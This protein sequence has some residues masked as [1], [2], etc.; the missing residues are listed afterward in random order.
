MQEKNN[1]TVPNV[2]TPQPTVASAVN[3]DLLQIE[4]YLSQHYLFRNNVLSGKYEVAKLTNPQGEKTEETSPFLPLTSERWNTIIWDMQMALPDVKSVAKSAETFVHSDHT[5]TFDPV[6]DYINKLPQ[7]DG[8]DHV[9]QLIGCIPGLNGYQQEWIRTWLRS[10]VAHWMK[11]DSEFGNDVVLLLIGAQGCGKSTFCQRLIPKSLREYYLDHLNLANKFDKEM[12]LARNLLVN[13]DEFD[14]VK[15]SQQAELKHTISKTTVNGRR[16][17]ASVQTDQHRYASFVATTNSRHPLKDPT[18]SRRYLC[19]EIP[20]RQIIDNSQDIDYEQLYAQIYAELKDGKRCYFT[21]EEMILM[22]QAN[23]PYQQNFD[24]TTMVLQCFRKPRKGE[25]VP[26]LQVSDMMMEVYS[27]YPQ[28][29]CSPR[30]N[31][32]LGVALR[33]QGY[34]WKRTKHGAAYYAVIRSG[35]AA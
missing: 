6:A 23:E 30:N 16:I 33:A 12:A 28:L 1:S 11:M 25:A 3:D 8:K 22:Q 20:A 19:V 34:Q 35:Q 32:S 31:V 2:A 26:A 17:Y 13:I 4:E 18:G 29:A 27:R 15:D 14:Q 7:W 21:R 5:P 9:G 24:F 10:M